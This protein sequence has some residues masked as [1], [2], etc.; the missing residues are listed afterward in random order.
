MG[1]AL[2]TELIEVSEDISRID[3]GS[4][5]VITTSFEGRSLCA[6][7]GKVLHG[8]PFPEHD[9][10]KQLSGLW[11][12]SLSRS[13]FMDY[14]EEIRHRIAAG[15]VYQ[16]N[17][18]RILSTEISG[19]SLAPLFQDLLKHNPAPYA[20]FLRLNEL[21]IASVSPELFLRREGQRIIT[22]P[23]KG[24]KSLDESDDFGEKD[25]SENLMIVDLMRNDLGRIA[26]VGSVNTSELFR[27]ELH[28][29]LRQMVSD[30]EA[31]LRSDVSW[32]QI[33]GATMPPGSVSGAPKLSA[34]SIIE[35]YEPSS[36][37][38]YCGA[39][40]WV[41]G[42]SALLNVSIR[43]FSS[44]GE[45]LRL[46]V[47]AGIT[48]GS[49]AS[50]EWEE[51][52]LKAANLLRIAGGT[53]DN[54]WALDSGIFETIRVDEGKLQFFARHMSR[55]R[56]SGIA[57]GIHIPGEEEI[58]ALIGEL[59]GHLVLR[60]RIMFGSSVKIF[61]QKYADD[62]QPLKV[63]TSYVEGKPGIGLHKQYPYDKNLA[64]L[65]DAVSDGVDEV[66]L[67]GSNGEVG[68][69]AISSYSF[70]IDGQWITP[71]L[72]SGAL[73]GIVRGLAVEKG[74]IQEGI[75]TFDMLKS[76]ESAVAMSS[77][78]IVRPVSFINGKAL[79]IGSAIELLATEIWEIMRLDSIG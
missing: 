39:F 38:N 1:G 58:L 3:D 34:I 12:S 19:E 67:V 53:D 47:G 13:E 64:M 8:E 50:Q 23:M 30:V 40:G 9:P 28:P 16:V 73:P 51:T 21:E 31:Q 17:A 46:G 18:C 14:V 59:P 79:E 35:K 7:F 6:K 76:V 61:W 24:T 71:R 20:A 15:E 33:L 49:D 11:R 2:A 25:K 72:E 37:E 10:W 75:V 26:K 60:L 22:S 4:F 32:S 48:W 43:T 57:L 36:R 66:L 41:Q 70:L 42:D 63:R 74:L 29:G 69:G 52:T 56:A 27:N 54:G 5:W 45:S 68:E 55:A 65:E 77:M 44:D 62:P 78:K